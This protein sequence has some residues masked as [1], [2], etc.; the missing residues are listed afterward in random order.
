[1]SQAVP[2]ITSKP[3]V[4]TLSASM[5]FGTFLLAGLRTFA[6]KWR[7][8]IRNCTFQDRTST[9]VTGASALRSG[10]SFLP[11]LYTER[12]TTQTRRRSHHEMSQAVPIITS[13]PQVMTLSASMLF[14]T[15]LLAGLR[16]FPENWRTMIRNCTFQ[17]RT[18]TMVTG[19]SAL[20]SGLSF[21]PQ[22]YTERNMTQTRRRSHHEMSQAVPIITSRPQVMTLSASM[23]FEAF[24]LAGLR[25]FAEKWR[26]MIRNCTFQDK[27]STI[28][29]GASAL[30]S[31][32]SFLPQLYTERNMTQTRRRSHH[33]MSQ[34][35]LIITS[36]PQVMTLSASML[37]GTFL[38]AGL[39][40]FA[41][42]WRTMIRNCT[43]Q[44]RTST[45]VTE[46]SMTRTV[47]RSVR[48]LRS[49]EQWHWT[50]KAVG[51]Y[52][53]RSHYIK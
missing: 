43:F 51:E 11:Q 34:A 29:T 24:L 20:R 50:P 3:Q 40:T 26:T 44:D 10:L 1:M 46:H 5:L 36:R 13:R 37:F 53:I 41:E 19:A 6:E 7:T 49:R 42:K 48:S 4:M 45:I 32:L 12:N 27:T 52:I 18:S 22:L 28:V 21:L 14:G 47:F 16:T 9:I 8:M 25:T 38:L 30:R 39:R 2:I 23:L 17:D 15:F 35:V 33:E 31:G